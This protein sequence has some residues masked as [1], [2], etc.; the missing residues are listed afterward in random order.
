[1]RTAIRA[2][3]NRRRLRTKRVSEH[4]IAIIWMTIV[5]PIL[6]ALVGM[7]VDAAYYTYRGMQAQR[8]ADAAA[9]GGV[10]FLPDDV[11]GGFG[12]ADRLLDQNGFGGTKLIEQGV[13]PNQLTV[14]VTEAV[15]S[16]F[17][18]ILG[19]ESFV[20]QKRS[21][22]EYVQPLGLGSPQ[23]TLG[24]DPESGGV[25]PNFWL[26]QFGPAARK[27]DG[28]RFGAD[29]CVDDATDA[30]TPVY[31]CNATSNTRGANSEFKSD[32]YKY[33]ISTRGAP[34]GQDLEISIFD[35]VT[36]STGSRCDLP[37]FPAGG[38]MA[39]IS[40]WIADATTRYLDGSTAG[41][42]AWCTGDHEG[43]YWP[44][45]YSG[46]APTTTRFDVFAPSGTVLTGVAPVNPIP[47]PPPPPVIAGPTGVVPAPCSA[48]SGPA[49]TLTITNNRTTSIRV[50]AVSGACMQSVSVDIAT[51]ANSVITTFDDTRWRVFDL[52]DNSLV[53]DF[54]LAVGGVATT[55]VYDP[56]VLAGPVVPGPCS[57]P[58]TTN[59]VLTIDNQRTDDIVLQFID[60]LCVLTTV[61]T[62]PAG[63]AFNDNRFDGQR[64][65]VRTTS[66]QLIDDFALDDAG[67]L[68]RYNEPTGG[69]GL[70][71]SPVCRR[72]FHTFG[73]GPFNSSVP[74]SG[75]MFELLYPADGVRDN[76]GGVRDAAAEEFARGF[77]R[78]VTICRIPAA[79]VAR[80]LYTVRV[81]TDVEEP[82]G[83]TAKNG[84]SIRAAWVDPGTG[85]RSET[86]LST[87]ALER[88]P[89][90]VNLGGSTS[91]SL[92]MTRVTPEYAGKYLRVELFDIGDTA[93]GTVNLTF[94]AP[95]DGTGAPWTCG[96]SKVTSAAVTPTGSGCTISGLTRSDFNGS[97]VRIRVAVPDDYSCDQSVK[98]NCW[99]QISMSFNGGASP[100]DQTTWTAVIEGD[101]LRLVR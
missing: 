50:N 69:S 93:A 14:T 21:V 87:T 15:P 95:A 5:G 33:G 40:S 65:Q 92:H 20:L 24:N 56:P 73:L 12:E 54:V 68:R 90:Y 39:A 23:A 86:G 9:L 96:I 31:R 42:L 28:D 19:Q 62:I 27:H 47:A 52:G 11:T 88:L 7:A 43:Y 34:P 91:S 32:G 18:R 16:F 98:T 22:A 83:G 57:A 82:T 77:R 79:S 84:Y 10:V 70:A 101:P 37:V 81:R 59:R 36:A 74:Y 61:A 1:M 41:G 6:L 94:V 49:H 67:K 29:N 78:W 38:Q 53:D 3:R 8:S 17:A 71:E 45:S 51:G 58:P 48:V 44:N 72:D 75:T 2:C 97:V 89:V 13:K 64:F 4:G 30:N 25:Q 46:P 100:T 76:G 80:G 26:S 63:S 99:S 35:P 55:N 60:E 85:A 66:S